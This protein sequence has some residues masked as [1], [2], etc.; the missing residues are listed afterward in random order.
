MYQLLHD[1]Y[2]NVMGAYLWLLELHPG[3]LLGL[4]LALDVA[5][6]LGDLNAALRWEGVLRFDAGYLCA[7]LPPD[8][9]LGF[10]HVFWHY[11]ILIFSV[12]INVSTYWTERD[13][14]T[15]RLQ[16]SHPIQNMAILLIDVGLSSSSSL[17]WTTECLPGTSISCHSNSTG[18]T[19]MCALLH[20]LALEGWS[21]E[22]I[23]K[24]AEFNGMQ[25]YKGCGYLHFAVR[26]K[27]YGGMAL[28]D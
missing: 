20:C 5:Y 6:S 18:G 8:F 27:G 3:N 19:S 4:S 28:L 9:H 25:F 14:G 17:S 11:P 7:F 24:L 1:N 2:Q 10:D 12:A 15:L 23:S 16:H 22:M 13:G 26:M 21:A